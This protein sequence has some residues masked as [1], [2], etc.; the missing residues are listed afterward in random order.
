MKALKCKTLGV[1]S[2]LQTVMHTCKLTHAKPS[3]VELTHTR[4]VARI[5]VRGFLYL[6][7]VKHA[8]KISK[9]RPQL[10][11]TRPRNTRVRDRKS[12]FSAH[13]TSIEQR[14]CVDQAFIC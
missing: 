9:P 7:R 14:D 10:D 5:I 13:F 12:G 6:M 2:K 3:E 4:G 11:K 1:Q 8:A